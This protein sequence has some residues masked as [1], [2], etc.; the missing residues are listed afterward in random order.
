[1]GSTTSTTGF[2]PFEYRCSSLDAGGKSL[3]IVNIPFLLVISNPSVL[4]MPSH[5][6]QNVVTMSKKNH[7]DRRA[8]PEDRSR[9]IRQMPP[10]KYLSAAV[11]PRYS[12]LIPLQ[13]VYFVT[14]WTGKSTSG[15]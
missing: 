4:Y 12:D 7:E 6:R 8:H 11:R 15:P 10:Y 1:V 9:L 14:Q 2:F 5:N 13:S 3:L